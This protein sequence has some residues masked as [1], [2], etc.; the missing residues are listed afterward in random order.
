MM[1]TVIITVSDSCSEGKRED[2]S[3][4]LIKQIIE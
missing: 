1:K 2:T 3:G 4:P